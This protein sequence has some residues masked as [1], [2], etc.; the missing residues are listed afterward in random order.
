M[1][2]RKKTQR[3]SDGRYAWEPKTATLERRSKHRD[4]DPLIREAK[5]RDPSFRSDLGLELLL[6]GIDYPFTLALFGNYSLSRDRILGWMYIGRTNLHMTKGCPLFVSHH[7]EISEM[8]VSIAFGQIRKEDALK[9]VEVLRTSGLTV[10]A[11]RSDG[12]RTSSGGE[13]VV[14]LKIAP[15]PE[16]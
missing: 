7:Q 3:L 10:Q 12:Y 14:P 1:P 8:M 5:R 13:Y 2:K 4:I 6:R 9:L 15:K 16:S 11:S